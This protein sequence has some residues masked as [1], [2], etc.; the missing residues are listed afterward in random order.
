MAGLRKCLCAKNSQTVYVLNMRGD[1][2]TSGELSRRE[3]GKLFGGGSRAP[4]T[5]VVFVKNPQQGGTR[6]NPLPRH[7]RLPDT[8]RKAGAFGRFCGGPRMI[9]WRQIT[10]DTYG[11]WINQRDPNFDLHIVLGD[12]KNKATETVFRLFTRVVLKL[13]A[14]LGATTQVELSLNLM[15]VGAWS[16]TIQRLSGTKEAG[17]W[18]GSKNSLTTIQLSFRGLA[19]GICG[20]GRKGAKNQIYRRCF[21]QGALSPVLKIVVLF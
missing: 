19:S 10:P 21:A 12:K 8:R 2:R 1:Q 11:D 15:F 17:A 13:H 6:A 3:G 14:T 5:I 16:S 18:C 20:M 7:R 9:P 4:I